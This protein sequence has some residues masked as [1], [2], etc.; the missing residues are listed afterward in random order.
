[1]PKLTHQ[2]ISSKGGKNSWF[3]LTPEEREKKM[4]NM[5]RKRWE[6]KV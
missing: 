5:R 2:Q 1:M 6:K 3:K 4:K